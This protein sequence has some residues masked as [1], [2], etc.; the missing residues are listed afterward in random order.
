VFRELGIG[1]VPY[2]PIGRGFF[3]GRAA[4]QSI[5]SESWL[6]RHPRYNGENLEKNKVFYTRIEELATKYG[7]SP[8]QLA[9]SWV[10]HQGD[11]VVPIPGNVLNIFSTLS[12]SEVFSCLGYS[13]LS[14]L[15]WSF[16]CSRTWFRT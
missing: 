6:T 11:D 13:I 8:A 3:A 9:L 2:S 5:P 16:T 12:V 14:G 1:I 10:L 4:V 7:C 15:T